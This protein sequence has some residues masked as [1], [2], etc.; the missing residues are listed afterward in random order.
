MAIGRRAFE[1][2]EFIT[3]VSIPDS[4]V[5]ILYDAFYSCKQLTTVN[6]GEN[7]ALEKIGDNAFSFCYKLSSLTLPKSVKKIGSSAF[8][9]CRQLYV[10]EDLVNYLG[11]WAIG[12]DY[13]NKFVIEKI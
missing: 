4:V 1:D 8:E 9:S 2:N 3:S 12:I 7:S 13:E 10:T 5:E 11:S 6:F